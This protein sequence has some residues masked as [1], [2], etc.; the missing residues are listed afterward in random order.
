MP[1]RKRAWEKAFLEA[2]EKLGVISRAAKRAGITRQT[3]Y[4]HLKVDPGF[5][6]RVQ[7]A[8]DK[9]ADEV[10]VEIMR[11]AMEGEKTAIYHNGK[12]IGYTYKKSDSLLIYTHKNLRQWH[13]S[14]KPSLPEQSQTPP[15]ATGPTPGRPRGA[16]LYTDDDGVDRPV[17]E[18]EEADV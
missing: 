4:N 12:V 6:D 7:M 1:K 11:R 13:Q 9:A 18:W 10:E 2:L 14:I 17:S 8:L 15:P 3:V 16:I 5:A